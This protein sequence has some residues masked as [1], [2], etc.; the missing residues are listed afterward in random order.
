MNATISTKAYYITGEDC[1]VNQ[2]PGISDM[3]KGPLF[4]QLVP[5]LR[6]IAVIKE[7]GHFVPEEQPTAFNEKLLTF[8]A[9][10]QNEA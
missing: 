10:L 5:N 7:S 3:I 6:E 1:A 9:D 2:F 8:L 4:K